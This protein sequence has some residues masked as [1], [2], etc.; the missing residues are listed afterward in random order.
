MPEEKECG[1]SEHGKH[2]EEHSSEEQ[3]KH[4][5]ECGCGCGHHGNHPH[6]GHHG[7]NRGWHHQERCNCECHQEQQGGAMSR[8]H[9]CGCGCGRHGQTANWGFRRHFISRDEVI[10]RL[11]EYLKQLQAEAKGVEEHI[12][13]LKAS[14][15]SK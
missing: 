2:N 13:E 14:S 15:E 11:E 9:E 3:E 1:C 6:H 12:A 4:S 7:M 5:E 8:G 10:T